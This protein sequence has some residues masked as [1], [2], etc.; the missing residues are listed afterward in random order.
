MVSSFYVSDFD[1]FMGMLERK[2][3]AERRLMFARM[4]IEYIYSKD[5]GFVRFGL[6]FKRALIFYHAACLPDQNEILRIY[7]DPGFPALKT[8]LVESGGSMPSFAE[9]GMS[10]PAKITDYGNERVVIEA[11]A[12]RD[13]WLLLLDSY[14]PGWKAT[15]DNKP[16]AIYRADGFFRAVPIPAGKHVVAFSYFPKIFRRSLAVFNNWG[17]DLGWSFPD[18]F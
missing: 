10:E 2:S 3:L 8:L 9:G 1:L 18:R 15:V 5:M 14:Y 4:G 13:G 6:P 11:D 7:G 12:R 16:A 17:L